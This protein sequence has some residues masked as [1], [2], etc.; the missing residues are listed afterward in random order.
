M[1]NIGQIFSNFLRKL[2]SR[3]VRIF[4]KNSVFQ[5]LAKILFLLLGILILGVFALKIFSPKY[6]EKF[7][8]KLRHQFFHHLHLDNQ[9]FDQI[10]I[11][12]NY[13]I[14]NQEILEIVSMVQQDLSFDDDKNYEP[15][16]NILMKRLKSQIPWLDKVVITRAMPNILNIA[17]VEYVPFAI[18]DGE[19]GRHLIDK[20]GNLLP[21]ENS[22]EF[23]DMIILSGKNAYLNAISLFNIF[24]T[25]PE[26]S[27]NI[28]SATWIS[29]RRWD[30]RLENGVIVKLP[31]NNISSSWQNLI[32]IYNMNGSMIGLKILDLR[33]P[34]KVYLEYDE[35]VIKEL[36]NL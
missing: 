4:L 14:K 20:D 17:V 10:N 16:M 22:Q 11:S 30:L 23:E 24:A 25:N 18:W 3:N 28:Y 29:D 19:S 34:N 6:S 15:M 7:W 27:K 36:K 12:G 9:V 33:I 21:Y 32:K 1:K 5:P 13:R 26:F 8:F 2:E 35:P 31:E